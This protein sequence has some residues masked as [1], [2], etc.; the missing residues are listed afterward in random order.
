MTDIT[1]LDRDAKSRNS[2]VFEIKKNFFVE[3]GAG[4]GKTTMLVNR[5]VAM[6]EA[7]IEIDKMCAITFTKAAAGEF[8]K[9]FQKL[10]QE[11]SNPTFVWTDKGQ[12]GQLPQ[13]T[14]ETRA[15][16]LRALQ[17]IDLCFMGTIDSFCNVILS[18]HPTE[19]GV[20]S[21]GFPARAHGERPFD[22][23]L[24]SLPEPPAGDH[25]HQVRQAEKEPGPEAAE[26]DP[27]HPVFAGGDAPD[28][29]L[30]RDAAGKG[31]GVPPY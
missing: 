7:G 14:E 6:V 4:S 27:G 19:A 15:R 26:A 5:M 16:C 8:Y 13:P 10:L 22:V 18:E 9:R 29:L 2:I 23:Q 25:R 17:N 30:R 21:G 12:A 31:R 28:P 20:P 11:R 3:A 24:G 1:N